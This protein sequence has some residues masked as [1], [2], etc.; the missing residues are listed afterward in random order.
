MKVVDIGCGHK[1]DPKATVGLDYYRWG[2][3]VDIVHDVTKFPWPIPDGTFDAAVSH[4]CIEHLPNDGRVAGDD[5][6]FRFFD[7][8]WRILRPG[9]RFSFDTPDYRSH[10]AW[11]DP[12]HRRTFHPNAFTFLWDANRDSLYPRKRWE[13]V[14]IYLSRFYGTSGLNTLQVKGAYPRLDRFLCRLHIGRPF[15]ICCTVRKP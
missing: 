1:R 9:G 12:T 4:Q 5:L 7:E 6:F 14:E 15:L 11:S 10:D 13:L 8:V 2:P 3:W